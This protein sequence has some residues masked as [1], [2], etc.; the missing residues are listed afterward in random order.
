M[1]LRFETLASDPALLSELAPALDAENESL[2]ATITA[3]KGLIFGA[4]SA[5]LATVAQNSGR[6]IADVGPRIALVVASYRRPDA[7]AVVVSSIAAQTLS[8]NEFEVAVVVDGRDEHE[9]AYREVLRQAVLDVGLPLRFEIQENAGQSVARHRAI[10]ATSAP[11]VVVIDDDMDLSPGFLAAHLSALIAG[12]EATVTIGK[13]IPE[14]GWKRQP[15]YEAARTLAM[16]ELH[17]GL[18][19]GA[20]RAQASAFV[21]QNVGFARARYLA[22][23]GFDENLRLGEDTELGLRMER[24]GSRYSFVEEASAVHRSRVGSYRTW[25]QR[26]V[27]YGRNAVYIHRKLGGNDA[28]PLRNL[29]NGSRLNALAVHGLCWS[30][31]LGRSGIAA[32]RGLGLALHGVGL[33]KP[34]IATHKAILA[35]AYHLGVKEAL[36]SW[37]ALRTE[38]R[39]FEASQER[40]MD[41]T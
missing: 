35:V 6:R 39:A 34:A 9:P 25:L 2:R 32:L 14:E 38:E 29:V 23:G 27:N 16:L 20:L 13:V 5:R 30:N 12:G 17:Q 24:S 33:V 10:L 7:L 21:T 28:H 41:P 8:R 31:A 26:Q 40:P 3:L 4:R 19:L 18:A 22:V 36:G 37:S 15:L 11:W 1:A